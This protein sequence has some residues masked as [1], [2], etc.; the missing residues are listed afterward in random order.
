MPISE[1]FQADFC[2][3]CVYHIYN[4]TSNK[5]LLFL[6]DENHSFFLRKYDEYLS[7]Y[8]E[9][10]AWCLLPNH[11]HLIVKVK[12]VPL[13]IDHLNSSDGKLSTTEQN[14][15]KGLISL[16]ELIEQSFK[17]FF[18]SYAQAF[19][20]VNKRKGNLFYKP[21]KRRQIETDNYFTQSIIYTHANPVKHKLTKDFRT[22]KWS[23]WSTYMSKSAT[24]LRRDE[25]VEWFGSREEFI[26]QHLELSDYYYDSEISIED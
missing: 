11:F 10:Y 6:N 4:R 20:K 19:N 9:T 26:R 25:V 1:K 7:P 2:E 15:K 17:R 22:W 21:F 16:S 14:F 12:P 5:E 24:K 23:S 13:V 8:L 3:S 18:Q